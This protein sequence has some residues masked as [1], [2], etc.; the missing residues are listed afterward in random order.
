[1]NF[2]LEISVNNTTFTTVDLFPDSE[3]EY[4]VDF[5]DN[6]D[7]GSI[8]LPFFTTLKIPL[9]SGN[10]TTFGY[11]PITSDKDD[12][13]KDD[14]YF[15]ITAFG[16]SNTV[17]S[18]M[19]NITAIEYN[20]D[21]SYI[22][23]TLVDFISKYINDLKDVSLSTLYNAT[24]P[25]YKTYYNADHTFADF[26]TTVASGGEGGTLN[27]NPSYTR[28][29]IFPYIDFCGDLDTFGY[30]ARQFTE[31]GV[32]MDRT[33]FVPV[34]SV[35]LF[36][37]YLGRY[38]TD[39]GFETRV[40]S[41]LF[42]LNKTEAIPDFQAEKLHMVLPAK[43][44]AKQTTNT[45]EFEIN[46]MPF[47]AGTNEDMFYDFKRDDPTA[48]KQMVTNYFGG[49]ESHGNY[50]TVSEATAAENSF[51]GRHIRRY[52]YPVA[53]FGMR[54]GEQG[55]FAPH[56]SFNAAI[57]F[58]SDSLNTTIENL[59]LDIP[60][61]QDDKMVQGI[62]PASSTMKF[63]MFLGVYENGFPVKKIRLED[64][65]GDPIE[66]NASDATA[67][68]GDSEK[69][70]INQNQGHHFFTNSDKDRF[71]IL[72]PSSQNDLQTGYT[73]ALQW[74]DEITVYIPSGEEIL[75]NGESRYSTNYFLE[76]VSGTL[77]ITRVTNVSVHDQHTSYGDTV[78]TANAEEGELRKTITGSTDYDNLNLTFKANQDYNLYFDDDV[79]TG[80]SDIYN[81]KSSLENTATTKPYDILLAICKR[82]NCGIFYESDGGVNIL[83]IDPIKYVREGTEN[84]NQYIDDLKS[85]KVAVGGDKFKNI[86]LNNKDFSHFYDDEAEQ[87]RVIGS[88]TQEINPE[89]I[90]DL[91]IN[92]KSGI[93]YRSLAGSP[94]ENQVNENVNS[95]GV[96]TKEIAFTGNVFTKHQDI[97]LKFAYVD[98]PL[99]QTRIKKPICMTNW[100]RLS[101]V[102][103]TQRIYTLGV[104]H[105]FNGRLFNKNTANW[106]L[107]AENT[108]GD[109]TD[110][111]DFYVDDEKI[112][113]SDSPSIEFSMVVPTTNLAN[114]DFLF[115]EFT[116]SRMVADTIVIKSVEG[117]VYEDNAYLN[118]KGI[119]K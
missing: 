87:G 69:T 40:D 117:E 37:E 113:Y 108:S 44:E 32:G 56:M 111:Y 105:T 19:L 50:N 94:L 5:Y 26:K 76:P 31:Y 10:Q 102:T 48:S 74:N 12:F 16:T 7:V 29:I 3:L 38:I 59:T 18:G 36:L 90:S 54:A 84:I 67:I 13:P 75:I 101:L 51:Y 95:G 4:N 28:P 20:S 60:L 78:V 110:Y 14:Y 9:T 100:Q 91:I 23:V 93:F 119:L 6:L 41:S 79:L 112:T 15:R 106:D 86:T 35:K 17:I 81:V 39:S 99:F 8:K 82:F 57:T 21:E 34:F 77:K 61:I 96:S 24:N 47:C 55:F 107:L 66:L 63:N 43:L 98:K 116:A 83:R 33:G 80:S 114:L 103:S 46:Q 97:G 88:T 2:K 118:V 89:G 104:Q 53:Q 65:N 71:V 42:G 70:N 30:G 25:S 1:M 64:V 58:D 22:D 115:K 68:Q 109:T 49:S 72:D 11:T 73:D 85:F 52:Y 27:T 62:N 45:R 92:F